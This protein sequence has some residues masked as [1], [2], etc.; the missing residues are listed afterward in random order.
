MSFDSFKLGDVHFSISNM[1]SKFVITSYYW[2]KNNINKNSTKSLTYGQQVD[3]LVQSCKKH[4]C[5]YYII[6]IPEFAQK[7]MY[8]T[9]INMKFDFIEHAMSKCYPRTIAYID[10]DIVVNKYPSLFD[11]DCDIW[12]RNNNFYFDD[13]C[14]AP[15]QLDASGGVMAFANNKF[16]KGLLTLFKNIMKNNPGKVE[17]KMMSI[18]FTEKY[19]SQFVRSTWLPPSYLFM[20]DKNVWDPEAKKY[21]Y[22]STLKEEA[23]H[24]EIDIDDIVFI[25]VDTETAEIGTDLQ[26]RKLLDVRWPKNFDKDMGKKLRCV[27]QH[28]KHKYFE[29]IDFDRTIE[30]Q[31]ELISFQIDKVNAKMI[32]LKK[33]PDLPIDKTKYKIIKSITDKK[34]PLIITICPDIPEKLIKSCKKYNLSYVIVINNNINKPLLFHKLLTEFKKPIIYVKSTY[35][36]TSIPTFFYS[37]NMDFMIFNLNSDVYNNIQQYKKEKCVDPRV[38]RTI[39]SDVMYFAYNNSILNFLRIWCSLNPPSMYKKGYDFKTLEYAFNKSQMT[40][41]LR[42]LWL[43]PSYVHI[44]H[45][46][47]RGQDV[48]HG[49]EECLDCKH[50][51]I[52][53]LI[54][55][56]Y[57]EFRMAIEQCGYKPALGLTEDTEIKVAHYKKSTYN[58]ERFNVLGYIDYFLEY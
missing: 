35:E 5:N 51:S 48:L 47:V 22:L 30:Q 3:N 2:G 10:S 28:N 45:V 38:L 17:D 32:E 16:G 25:H 9:A 52:Y 18:L 34:S 23:E 33:V 21:T 44:K 55:K 46:M 56:K 39:N 57:E 20:F 4:N 40:N 8:Q 6:E 27:G 41:H 14:Y 1:D 26:N 19:I 54:P 12:A 24:Q 29:Y 13:I 7:G 43:P 53:K 49:E 31:K 42:C 58:L 11:I 50:S 36:F 37:I 15:N